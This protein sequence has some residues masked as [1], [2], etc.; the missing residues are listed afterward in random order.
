M[1]GVILKKNNMWIDDIK[2]A[3]LNIGGTG[4]YSEIYREIE[5]IR[6]DLSGDWHAVVRR[7][8]QQNSSDSQSWLEN[9]DVFFSVDGIGKGVWGVRDLIITANILNQPPKD[10]S[11]VNRANYSI[12]RLIR[13]TELSRR[14]KKYHNNVCQVCTTKLEIGDNLFYSEGHHVKPLG[15]P[16]NGPDTEDNIIVL[17]P[18]C[19]VLCD[20]FNIRLDQNELEK[21]GRKLNKE[22]IDYHNKIN[23]T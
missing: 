6:K 21:T 13:D 15:E 3:I 2:Q 4:H 1:L 20:N 5:R 23:Y 19:H 17:C 9:R 12:S 22:F 10:Y 14:I 7:T 11:T 16:H 18:N 8:I